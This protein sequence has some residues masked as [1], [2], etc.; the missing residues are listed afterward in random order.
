M[1]DDVRRNHDPMPSREELDWMGTDL[2]R[3]LSRFVLI[4]GLAIMVGVSASVLLER[5][6]A[7][8]TMAST[9]E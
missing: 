9:S 7:T 2:T 3:F 4:A 5:Y 6:A 1:V 8:P